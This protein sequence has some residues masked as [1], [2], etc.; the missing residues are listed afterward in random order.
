MSQGFGLAG[1]LQEVCVG[2]AV[3]AE[4][5]LDEVPLLPNVRSYPG[6]GGLARETQR[7]W[8]SYGEALGEVIQRQR[9]ILCDPQ[10]SVAC[11]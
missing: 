9:D 3:H 5:D 6:E 4:R 11:G 2:R 7:N 1:G 8:D 10:S